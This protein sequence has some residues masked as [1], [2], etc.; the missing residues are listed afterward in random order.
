MKR[1]SIL[2]LALVI[3]VLLLASIDAKATLPYPCPYSMDY[4]VEPDSIIYPI[5]ISRGNPMED[6]YN[7]SPLYLSD[8][9]N[10]STE[11]IYDPVTQQYT[12]KR[13]IGDFY[14][15]TPAT[16][17]Q[18]EY[19]EYQS[20]KGILDY[21]KDR[22]SQNSRST[23][24]G[25]SIIPPIYIG[26]K[27]FDMIFGSN[28]VDIRPQGSVDLTFGFK[29][30]Y[31]G[32]PSMSERQQNQYN[33]DFD[34]DI[35][36][37]VMAKIGDKINFNINKN[38][39][40][41]FNYQDK[42]A[43]KYDGKED[44][45]IQLLEAG[46]VS[47]PLNSTLITGTQQLFGIK[48]KLRFG[49]TT[50]SSIVS[51]Q[52]SE[53]QNITVQGG[54]QTNEFEL[55]CLDYEENRH[56]F[57]SQ[58]FRDHYEEA[59]ST[60]PTVTSSVNITKIEVW[61]TNTNSST[62]NT[63]NILALTDLGEGKR[64]WIYNN[65]VAPT[66]GTKVYPRNA[67]NN[68]VS[69][70]DTTQI[71][72]IS[73]V[74]NYMS[75]DPMRIGR[76]GY[77]VSG[78]DFEK[79]E[80]ARRL[81]NTEFTLNSKLGFISLNVTLNSNQTL[82]VAY[83]YT[84]VGS[85]EVYQVG[86]FS[87]QG[88]NTPNVLVAKLLR[89]TTVNT[90][91]PIWNLMMKNVYNIRAYQISSSDFMLNIFY[92]G[93]SNSTPIGYFT[94][95]SVKG[96]PLLHL[97]GLDNLTQQNN[98]IPGGDGVF[99]FINNA[100]T[101]GGT[102]NASNGR[103]FF[104]VL[105]PFGKHIRTK[106]FPEESSLANKYAYDSLYTMTKT[107]AEQFSEKNKFTLKGYYSSQS[108][109]E[110]SLNAMNVAQG[111]VT[112]TAGG[113]Q[114][115]ENVDYTVD[116]TLGRVTIINEGI[117]NSG[118]PINIS[119]EANSGFSAL[120]KTFL[121]TRIEHEIDR[122]FRLGGTVLYL[123]EKSYTQKINYG[124]EAIANT[125]Y[126]ADI[127]YH[128]EARW[129]TSLIDKLPGIS[130]RTPSRIN[131]DGEFARFIPGLSR[132]ASERGTSYIDDFEGAKSTI[133]LRLP[134]MWVMASTPQNQ[135]DLFP[136]AAAGT[137]L[138]YG[139]NRAK[140]SWYTIDNAV[141]Y[142]RY[143]N[144]RPANVT[145]DELSKN[146]VRQVLETEIFPTK[147]IAAGTPTNVSVLNLAYYPEERGPYN[148]DVQPSQYSAGINA[149]GKLNN[150]ESRWAGIMRKM[151]T[152]DF[153]ATNIEYIEFWLMDPFM[154]EEYANNPGKLYINLGDISED[155][156][157]DGRKFYENGLPTSEN[158]INVDTTIWGRVPTLQD[159]VGTFSNEADARQYQ[160]VGFDGLRDVD[161]RSF[162]QETYLNVIRDYLGENSAAYANAYD[163]PSGDNYHHFRSSE[164]D[165]DEIHSSVLERYKNYNG[166]EGNSPSEVQRTE[167]YS[168][169]NS[170]LPNVEDINNDNTL[171]ESERYYQ[172]VIDL[173]PNQMVVGKNHIADILHSTNVALPNGQIG[174]ATWYQF[175]IPIKQPDKVIGHID[176][177]S[178]IRFMRM[179]VNEFKRP[180]VL[181]FA[182]LDLVKGEWRTYSQS[183]QAPGE[184]QPDDANNETTFD[185]SAVSIDENSRRAPVPYVI[186]PGIQQEKVIGTTAI[187]RINEQSLQMTVHNL[188]DGDGRAIYKTTD[189]DFRQYKY[190]K[191]FVHA[192]AANDE[193]QLQD[194]DLTVFL[195]LG[196]DFTENYYEYE[197]PLKVTPWQT[198]YTNKDA[199]WPEINNFEIKLEDLVEV[200]SHRNEAMNQPNSSVRTNYIYSEKVKKGTID[201]RDY[202]HT[203]KVIGNPSI[204]DVEAMMIGV[205]NPKRQNLASEDDGQPKSA[206]IW[207]NELRLT[208]LNSNGGIAATGRLEATLADL[209]RMSVT[210][211]YSS[212][213][214]GALDSD[215]ISNE[216]EANS[217][218]AV[219][220]DLELGKFFENTGLKIPMHIDYG[221]NR[222]TPLYNPYDP[223]IKMKDALDA[224]STQEEKD[225]LTS[226]IHDF[227]RHKNINFMNVRKERVNKR[228]RGDDPS[229]GNKGKSSPRDPNSGIR[230]RANMPKVHIYDIENFNLSF[231]YNETFQENT[232]IKYYMVKTYRG[233][234]GYNYAGN[235]K[236]VT[237]FGKAKWASKP[238][239]QIIKDI[240]FYYLPKSITFNT[241]MYRYFSQREMRNK[242]GGIV[243]IMPT[244]SKQWD[245]NRNYQ[246]RYDLT[247]GLS[248]DYS[249]QAQ[250]YIYEPA[251]YVD[252]SVDPER[253]QKNRDTIKNELRHLG[254][255]SRFQQNV[256]ATYT[257][258]INKI[259]IFNWIT[260]SAN[261]QGSYFWTA[262]AQSI[263]P[264]LGNEIENSNSLQGNATL[265]FTKLYNKV[266]YLKQLNT[267]QRRNDSKG[268][269]GKTGKDK[270]QEATADSTKTKGVNVGKVALDNGL[271]ILTLV[272]KVSG[273]YSLTNGQTL[274]GFMPKP[275]YLGMN[276]NGWSPGLGFVLGSSFGEDADIFH[277]AVIHSVGDDDMR[278]LT[279]D[280]I[281]SDPY[282]RR[283]TETM[284][285]R[286]N[287]EPLMGLKIDITGNRTMS[288][289]AQHYFRYNEALNDFEVFTPTNNGNFSTSYLMWGTSFVTSDS[290][291]SSLFDNLLNYR[292]IIAERIAR[293]NPQWIEN[294]NQY[295]FDSIAGDYFPV[296]YGSSSMDVLMYSF[297]AAYTGK[298]PNKITLNPFPRFPLPNWNVTFNGLSTIPAIASIFK[299]VSLTHSY[300][301]NYAISSWASN[302][303]Y[304]PNNTI[305]TY[306]NSDLIIPKYDIAQMVITEQ[307]APLIGVDLGF[308]N[309]MTANLQFKKSRTLTLSF[310][311][312]Q[313]TEVSGRE[314]VIGAGYR[315]KDLSFVVASLTGGKNQTIKNDLILKFDLG[316]KRDKTILR[317]IDENNNQISAGQD[318]IN[319][320]V[321]ADYT[322]S[323]RLSA[324]AFI[325]H[326]MTNPFV[327][328]TFKNSTTFAGVTIRFSL[329]Q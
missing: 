329:A 97:M 319:I 293:D 226:S 279:M 225:A 147:D 47:F 31:R 308:Q 98:P 326:D 213:G 202:Y 281:L 92:N 23:T 241:E 186:P 242:T 49:K 125:I 121:G 316:F 327:A 6:L 294:V 295:K 155:V 88:I 7:Q 194:Q 247:K 229:D 298:D 209:G 161:E 140:L 199:I 73:M 240:N 123:G 18:S 13:R 33:F 122:D 181:R 94:E 150:P 169:S 37:N 118:T 110:I 144:M 143:A 177:F 173:D 179:F 148:Y 266:P 142:D 145:P 149:Q 128:T 234:L 325:K 235:P 2:A 8:P 102:I 291:H 139:K 34:E 80:N 198:S 86:E 159:I 272:K 211:S 178:S 44:E 305:Q 115:V 190:L 324:Q 182:T 67:A 208:D 111:S 267:P 74:T 24:N 284:N 304:D 166:Q 269:G 236:N 127:S 50:I 46:N 285:Y 51:Y 268:K 175:R 12:F 307:F 274:P 180:V 239:L 113:A 303:Y 222:I 188:V 71:R 120:K 87:D 275:S 223:D 224:L 273:T 78:R 195:R 9:S 59:L 76:S 152:T 300:K 29:H 28:T 21:W 48:S 232:D 84:I 254:S 204:S 62:Q 146:S 69:R 108:G 218:F 38:T 158:V 162:F 265:D 310:A 289:N 103:I 11:I 212:A 270:G 135:R 112:V 243:N 185:I 154:D 231:S 315:I 245:W 302:V 292:K 191:M 249:A 176:D 260:T 248:L 17:T 82:A 32:D 193:Y 283:K 130:T 297:I 264:R 45:I 203:I 252:K 132:S 85:D 126:G 36:L 106:I 271:R 256:S 20:K 75:N 65:E 116:Y 262:S 250:A 253:W 314:I 5:P 263:Q 30:T 56:F 321:T 230:G 25:T 104:P 328:N 160:D 322:F 299:T 77:M 119:L 290:T 174:G 55:S 153:E 81:S 205:R 184:Y 201:N 19:L 22:R 89:G 54:A 53:S 35:Q 280:S 296:G 171:N 165:R 3:F 83:Q 276:S 99:D 233:G 246:V 206:V 157:R 40:A 288:E 287:A 114:L 301:S 100:A 261:Y 219:S 286:V 109:S 187:T 10:F 215:I 105:E 259:P 117:L 164:W 168:T 192:E 221:E 306:E 90:K 96:V 107:S 138:A 42:L 133:D 15:D 58:Y 129:L 207:V 14:Y 317:R 309:S 227:T 60:L 197:I 167:A 251:G 95:G 311:N 163:D 64:D 68:L 210:G 63:R 217:A 134:T 313:L 66:N 257:L 320:Y 220:T 151:E 16:M 238:A 141:F 200:K 136:E 61:I 282:R 101:Q 41:T 196:T 172:Y 156:L 255:M 124:E 244:Y 43:L 278:W 228:N 70:M 4:P 52:E 1:H 216:F 93:N 91:M 214:F 318:K 189:F 79:I 27:A 170:T 39:K 237:P 72:N 57:L 258:P 26:G 312:N 137:G 323:Q 277:K 131:V 183:I